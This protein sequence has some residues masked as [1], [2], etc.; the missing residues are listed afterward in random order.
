[1]SQ[2]RVVMD[3]LFDFVQSLLPFA[4]HESYGPA[5][6][7]PTKDQLEGLDSKGNKIFE[8]TVDLM[9]IT[10]D[11]RVEA[12]NHLLGDLFPGRKAN[13]RVPEHPT[14][15]VDSIDP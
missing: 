11:L 15:A 10:S 9:A 7:P 13:R 8:S 14:S 5:S 6:W 12:Q 4:R 2:D 3:Y 1:M